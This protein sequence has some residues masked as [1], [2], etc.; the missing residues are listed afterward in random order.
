MIKF[1]ITL[2]V[3]VI[4]IARRPV[5]RSVACKIETSVLNCGNL[6]ILSIIIISALRFCF[7]SRVRKLLAA[8]SIVTTRVAGPV[9]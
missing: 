3:C 8:H 1:R 9:T 4:F 5:I 2:G 7:L 6:S